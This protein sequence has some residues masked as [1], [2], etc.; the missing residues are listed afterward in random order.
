MPL[1]PTIGRVRLGQPFVPQTGPAPLCYFRG[2]SNERSLA[3][4][5][6]ALS[7]AE[8]EW[9]ERELA[10][11]AQAR[12]LAQRLQLDPTDV[13]HQLKQLQRSPIERLKRG[14]ALGQSRLRIAD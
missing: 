14:L 8:R 11:R 13:H 9:A 10:L 2:V 7:P 12:E 6:A 1:L 5:L 4:E 3:E